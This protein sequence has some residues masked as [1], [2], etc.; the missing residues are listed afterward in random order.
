MAPSV[1]GGFVERGEEGRETPK[2][3][4]RLS[5]S[6]DPLK[7]RDSSTKSSTPSGGNEDEEDDEAFTLSSTPGGE[8]IGG[9]N[10]NHVGCTYTTSP[11]LPLHEKDFSSCVLLPKAGRS[12][13][14][15]PD[16]SS[17]RPLERENEE[18]EEENGKKYIVEEQRECPIRHQIYFQQP[19]SSSSS[20]PSSFCLPSSLSSPPPSQS[21]VF[22]HHPRPSLKCFLD[23]EEEERTSL[24]FLPQHEL[25]SYLP[26]QKE[27]S[28]VQSASG[29]G[30]YFH[31]EEKHKREEEEQPQSLLEVPRFSEEMKERPHEEEE[32]SRGDA[33][34]L[35]RLV[36]K[37]HMKRAD[38]EERRGTI[39][40][41]IPS[42]DR[43][44]SS[45]FL[46]PLPQYGE[47]KTDLSFFLSKQDEEG[48]KTRE[49]ERFSWKDALLHK[50]I[51]E[52]RLGEGERRKKEED[53][54]VRG[55][56]NEGWYRE[57]SSY[58]SYSF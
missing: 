53:F 11:S 58:S 9:E 31:E 40:T 34:W 49:E 18:E 45:S 30:S 20:L 46:S 4:E 26:E 42:A 19:S 47:S 6:I 37:A 54:R 15:H 23:E 22:S 36:K 38:E 14:V 50:G 35:R 27:R 43:I 28:L 17:S 24:S 21:L 16:T 10:N 56:D 25:L 3:A 57:H 8:R 39:D 12:A 44:S 1:H 55:D 32:E 7:S 2:K 48:Q 33:G 29:R 13:F 51:Y 52:E 5:G 41:T